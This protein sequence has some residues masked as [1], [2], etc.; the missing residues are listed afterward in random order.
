[1]S[2]DFKSYSPKKANL[3]NILVIIPVR[4]EE[5][6]IAGVI[7]TLRTLGLTQIR[8]VDNGSS[9][10]SAAQARQ[11]GADVVSEPMA[12][13]GRA[14]W[15]GL[16][17]IPA[18]IEWI[19]FC[20][21]DG[22]D[23]L[24]E[25]P[26]FFQNRD[27]YD[28]ILGNRQATATGRNNL[29][30]VQ[31]FGNRLAGGLI[32][33]GWGYKYQDLGPL[34][35][36]RRRCLEQMEM[37][38]RGFGWTVEMQVRAI[39]EGLRIGELPV[40]YYPRKGGKSKISG[41]FVGSVKAGTVILS[42]LGNLYLRRFKDFFEPITVLS[43][44]FL[45][46]GALLALPFGELFDPTAFPHFCR[47]MIVMGIGFVLSWRIKRVSGISFWTVAVLCR[48]LLLPMASGDDIWRYLWEGY[49][50]TQGISPYDFPPNA[51]ELLAYRFSWWNLINHPDVSAIY[52]P[53][54]QLGFRLLAFITPSVLLFKFAFG[55]A[56]LAICGLL[57]RRFGY[58]SALLYAWN[59]LVIYSFSG[60]GHYDSWFILPLVMAWL[61]V[62]RNPE[63]EDKADSPYFWLLSALFLGISIG[64]KWMSLPLLSFLLWNGWRKLGLKWAILIL[65]V[66]LL[67]LVLS[68]LPFC[69]FDHCPLV[70]TSSVFV[71]HGRSAEFIP[72]WLALVWEGS[73]QTNRIFLIPLIIGVLAL[74][75]LTKSFRKFTESYFFILLTFSPIIHA[76]YFTWIIPFGVVT[77]NWGIRWVSLSSFVYFLLPY[78]QGLANPSWYLSHTERIILWFP[79]VM[80]WIWTI[81]LE[82]KRKSKI[83]S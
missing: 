31:R 82:N 34:R 60:G 43:G 62:D 23:D 50:Q 72:H 59:P 52:P 1:M 16:Q 2:S 26:H 78:R 64:I 68:I 3:T 81:I 48:L 10:R 57:A 28:F 51:P 73:R 77:Q 6:T 58:K 49:L 35:L 15:R 30:I 65:I 25:L 4:N 8:V 46:L 80:G 74:L 42:T 56:D 71:S 45:L 19:L 54:A 9:D 76:W 37:R 5:S 12:G 33:L 67:T 40:N 47:A 41:T 70:P 36:I 69:S 29:T 18:E 44:F 55:M 79:F 27:R 66:A 20:D 53:I 21:G 75:K 17:A 38:D 61:L 22:S 83:T 39:E 7:E 13:Y 24:H 32:R 14:C 11:A 63:P